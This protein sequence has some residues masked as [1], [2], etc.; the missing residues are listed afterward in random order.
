MP[1]ACGG[2]AAAV[3]DAS[4]LRGGRW[5]SL[6]MLVAPM[7]SARL[8]VRAARGATGAGMIPVCCLVVPRFS[9]CC[10][11]R[12]LIGVPASSYPFRRFLLAAIVDCTPMHQDDRGGPAWCLRGLLRGGGAGCGEA[13][14]FVAQ[15]H[16]LD[17][18][19]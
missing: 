4:G 12:S 2:P 15:Q 7:Q 3:R 16:G 5:R 1:S 17:E 9:L 19:E 14:G 6:A 10:Q 11:S 13:A 18:C 8:G